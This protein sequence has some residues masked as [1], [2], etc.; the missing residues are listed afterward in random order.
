MNFKRKRYD[1]AMAFVCPHNEGCLCMKKA[2]EN[3]GWHPEVEKARKE[4]LGVPKEEE[5]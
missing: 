5:S 3:C 4:K 2:C 1:S